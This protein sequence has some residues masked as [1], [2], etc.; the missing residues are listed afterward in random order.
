MKC[1]ILFSRKNKENIRNLSSADSVHIVVSVKIDR[2]CKH[3][4]HPEHL[5]SHKSVHEYY[6]GQPRI[7]DCLKWKAKLHRCKGSDKCLKAQFPT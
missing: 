2:C 4:D 6:F 3:S 5:Q 7:Q 1:P